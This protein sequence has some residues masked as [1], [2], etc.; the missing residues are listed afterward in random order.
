MCSCAQVHQADDDYLNRFG[1]S[2][3]LE[4]FA[5]LYGDRLVNKKIKTP[6]ALDAQFGHPG[7][8]D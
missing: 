8:A 3:D 1:A 7:R 5:R 4:A 2:I 6:K